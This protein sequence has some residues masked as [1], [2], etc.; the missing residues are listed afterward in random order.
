MPVTTFQT[1]E[2]PQPRG[3]TAAE[4]CARLGRCGPN[5]LPEKQPV[6]AWRRFA[7]QFRSPLIYILLFALLCA[8]QSSGVLS[9]AK[10]AA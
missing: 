5:A 8:R 1:I 6:T 3:L 2:R 10:R 7:A 9:L 4:A